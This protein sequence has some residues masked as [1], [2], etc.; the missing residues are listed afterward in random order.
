LILRGKVSLGR[1]GRALGRRRQDFG[2]WLSTLIAKCGGGSKRKKAGCR[3]C[4]C[5]RYNFTS[6]IWMAGS[7][8]V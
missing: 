6:L 2:E 5:R 8:L 7:T 1:E 3:L 4:L